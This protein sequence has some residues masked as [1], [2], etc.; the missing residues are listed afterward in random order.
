VG[1]MGAMTYGV[2]RGARMREQLVGLFDSGKDELYRFVLSRCGDRA[3]TEEVVGDVFVA[4]V[5]AVEEGHTDEVSVGWLIT[6]ARR[7]LVDHWRRESRHRRGLLRLMAGQ[8]ASV[9]EESSTGDDRA[10][11]ALGSLPARQRAAV[12]MRYLD[13]MSVGEIA[14]VLEVTYKTAESLL[15]R[16]RAGLR[17]AYEEVDGE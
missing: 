15:A 10:L 5:R 7:R 16:G 4:A 9:D 17:R 2:E 6:V 8:S 1:V 3:L 14:D 12:T 13:E 11:R